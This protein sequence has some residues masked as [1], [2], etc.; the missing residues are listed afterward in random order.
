MSF[1]VTAQGFVRKNYNDI[2]GELETGAK[3]GFG[4]DVDL[5]EYSPI[6]IFLQLMAD[7]LA[8]TWEKEEEVYYSA[9][10]NTATGSNLDR[11]VGLAGITRRPA[12]NALV[13]LRIA[14][15][16][17]TIVPVGFIAQTPQGI[18]FQTTASGTIAGG[19]LDLD[20]RAT[21]TGSAGNVSTGTVTEINTPQA[22]V[23][24]V[25][26]PAGAVGG[27]EV[28]T[29]S[30]LRERY[31]ARGAAGGSTALAI[32]AQLN[33]IPDVVTAICYENNE[34]TVV[35]GMPPHSI[36]AVLEGGTDQEILEALLV[37]KP[38]GIESFGTESGQIVD[39]AG[40]TRTFSW[41]R[42]SDQDVY[43]EVDIYPNAE[44]QAG[45]ITAVKQK[46]V[47][48]VGGSYA[49]TDYPGQGIGEDVFAWRVIAN[50]EDL[51]GI[52][53]VLVRVGETALPTGSKV[54]IGRAE[55]AVTDDAKIVVAVL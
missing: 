52:D 2:L 41:S 15:T 17:G 35:D 10:V 48:E 22:G 1:G 32:Q 9:Y 8:E 3:A 40:V 44:W 53:N 49:G 7:Q 54:D 38:A 28:E 6:G 20:A 31:Q 23:D 13:V 47:E 37:T 5:S 24:T 33:E 16:N 18:Q 55:R 21:A 51:V 14:G 19:T 39:N 26:N 34:D 29:D 4:N 46:V 25:T 50:L 30:E 12:T 36:E 43:V 27:A 42:P 11:V 45:F